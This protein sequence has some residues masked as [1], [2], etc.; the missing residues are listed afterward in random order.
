MHEL[1]VL[2]QGFD[3]EEELVADRTGA[4]RRPVYEGGVLLQHS[5]V[6]LQLL[7]ERWLG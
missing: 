1:H 5:Q 7:W 6:Q 2:Q 4:R 3:V